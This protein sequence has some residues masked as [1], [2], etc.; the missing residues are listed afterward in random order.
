MG[1]MINR[2]RAY[3]GEKEP[4][5]EGVVRIEYLGCNR[6]QFIN[7]GIIPDASM[8]WTVDVSIINTGN[9]GLNGLYE[10][11]NKRFMVGANKY[12]QFGTDSLFN[13]GIQ[14]D[15]RRHTYSI[16]VPNK[17]YLFDGIEVGTFSTF[18]TLSKPIFLMA[19]WI[20]NSTDY[21]LYGNFYGSTITQQGSYVIDMIP[22]R[23]GTTGYLYNKVS[24][25][26]FGNSG[27]GAFI[28]GPDK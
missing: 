3:G 28:L 11:P 22:V 24:G 1:I 9:G 25:Q 17:K 13:A 14:N 27:T 21:Q 12:V 4:L 18:P 20:N 23:R 26:L 19:R 5:P 6:T 2:R 8:V 10:G 7:T 16:D 15:E